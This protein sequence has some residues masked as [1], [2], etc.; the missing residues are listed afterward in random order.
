MHVP[1][2]TMNHTMRA[3]FPRPFLRP[4]AGGLVLAALLAACSAAPGGSPTTGPT[5]RPSGSA[6]SVPSASASGSP[7]TSAVPA[8]ILQPLL[9]DAAKRAKV[10]TS[11]ITIVQ[12]EPVTWTTGALGCP[13]PGVSY[14]QALVDGW[15]VVVTAGGTRIDYRTTAPGRFK[16]CEGLGG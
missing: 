8:D 1:G 11:A 6:S 14:T 15:H 16:V 2:P 13:T 5:D 10:D 9:A 3:P 7:A 12:A 4:F